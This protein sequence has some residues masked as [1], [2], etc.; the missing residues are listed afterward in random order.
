MGQTGPVLSI[1]VVLLGKVGLQRLQLL[2]A[3]ARPDAFVSSA[4]A[5]VFWPAFRPA[6]LLAAA[7]DRLLAIACDLRCNCVTRTHTHTCVPCQ[8]DGVFVVGKGF[9]FWLVTFAGSWTGSLRLWSHPLRVV[10]G[11]AVEVLALNAVQV[12]GGQSHVTLLRVHNTA[13]WEVQVL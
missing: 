8:S 4:G 3:E 11:V 10:V 7:A 12:P 1:G 2:A 9:F 13:R 6:V 5:P